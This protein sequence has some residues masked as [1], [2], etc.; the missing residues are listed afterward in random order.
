MLYIFGKVLIQGCQKLSLEVQQVPQVPG[1]RYQVP[2]TKHSLFLF[3]LI[4]FTKDHRCYIFLESWWYKDVRNEVCRYN[5]YHRYLRYQVFQVPKVSE[6]CC[7]CL[8]LN[9]FSIEKCWTAGRIYFWKGG[10]TSMSEIKFSGTTGTTG[11]SGTRYIRYIR[12][13]R[14]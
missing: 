12:Y 6:K 10:D 14:E 9:F 11:S 4:F 1:T 5:R 7:T 2:G 3:E 8:E 13:I